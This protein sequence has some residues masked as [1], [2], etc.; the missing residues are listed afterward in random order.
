MKKTLL[1]ATCVLFAVQASA[2]TTDAEALLGS[3][4]KL[5]SGAEAYF[6]VASEKTVTSNGQ[7][8]KETGNL[9][10]TARDAE[11]RSRVEFDD[12]SQGGVAVFDGTSRWVYIPAMRRYAQLPKELPSAAQSGGMNFDALARR[13]LDR[14]GSMD[15]RVLT[16]EAIREETLAMDGGE[17][18]CRVVE[19]AYDPPPGMREGKI[20]RTYWIA[21]ESGLVLQERSTASMTSPNNAAGRVEV[22]QEIVFQRAKVDRE[23]D[24]DLFVFVPPPGA[25]QVESLRPDAQ[26]SGAPV[27][28][29]APDFTLRDLSGESV[30]LSKQRGNVVLLDFWATWCGPCRYDMPFVQNLAERYAERG[31]KVFGMN[32]ENVELASAYLEQN[33]ITFPTLVDPGMRAAKLFQVNA[34]PTFV[35]IDRQGRLAGYMRG[36]RTEKQLEQALLKAGL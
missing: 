20:G 27:A 2:Q 23:L 16:A 36:T 34:L 30:Q 8:R 19:V 1:A 21:E 31:L 7:A 15:Q 5:Y 11:G 28:T 18:R 33:E 32:S 26:T 24:K 6:F 14:Y 3:A 12:R 4:A 10:L 29:E 17:V 9:V 25:Q 35:V 22:V 13:Y